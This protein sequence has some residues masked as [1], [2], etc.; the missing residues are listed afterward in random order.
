[1]NGID[2]LLLLFCCTR[3]KQGAQKQNTYLELCNTVL[4]KR[5]HNMQNKHTNSFSSASTTA[6]S[7]STSA[8]DPNGKQPSSR[9]GRRREA[10]CDM[11]SVL[12]ML[13]HNAKET[14]RGQQGVV[15][16]LPAALFGRQS[17]TWA[18]N[19]DFMNDVGTQESSASEH[20]RHDQAWCYYDGFD[21]YDTEAAARNSTFAKPSFAYQN[22]EFGGERSDVNSTM[23]SS[24]GGGNADGIT[25]VTLAH[26]C[27]FNSKAST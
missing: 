16:A 12:C 27:V 17:C 20:Q 3:S 15:V 4:L 6:A 18:Q 11:T 8:P 25:D 2:S 14:A 24:S 13:F 1:M 21:V 9:V 5:Y 26:R 19:F 23:D 10:S 7:T 22:P